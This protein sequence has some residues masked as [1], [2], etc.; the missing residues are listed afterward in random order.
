MNSQCGGQV[1]GR[2]LQSGYT[3]IIPISE[4]DGGAWQSGQ[5]P[6]SLIL[7]SIICEFHLF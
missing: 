4:H 2:G 1:G 5:K 6:K 7:H 3:P